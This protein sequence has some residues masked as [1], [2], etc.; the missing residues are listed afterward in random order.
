MS[1]RKTL[2][3]LVG[4]LVAAVLFGALAPRRMADRSDNVARVERGRYLVS[5]IG[6]ADCHAPKVMGPNGPE[7][8]MT[9]YLSGHPES[10]VMPEPPNF[11]PGAPWMA[12][13]GD[14]LTAWSGPWGVSYTANLTP[15]VNTGIGI[16]TEDMFLKAIRTGRHM[17]VSRPILP[18]MPW[19]F[20][21][22]LTDE[23]LKAIFTYLRTIPPVHNR[24]PDP[25]PPKTVATTDDK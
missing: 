23:D 10:Q 24:V 14:G 3:L 13:I 6:C 1:T 11:P 22:N 7:P 4:L 21:R 20:F 5:T 2:V 19:Q 12:S 16:W 9:R 15:D 25:V 17:G 18:P 8:D